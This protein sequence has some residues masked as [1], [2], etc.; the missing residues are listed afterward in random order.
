MSELKLWKLE[1]INKNTTKD[2]STLLIAALNEAE[3]RDEAASQSP[4]SGAVKIMSKYQNTPTNPWVSS[5]ESTCLPV[6]SIEIFD[7]NGHHLYGSPTPNLGW[8]G[9]RYEITEKDYQQ[10]VYSD[11]VKDNI[12]PS[13]SKFDDYNYQYI[14]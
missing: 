4:G 8:I 2:T 12:I 13:D 5:R 9:I 6:V 10:Q 14:T 7:R 3:A 1:L 11:G